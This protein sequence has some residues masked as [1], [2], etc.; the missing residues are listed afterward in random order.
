MY[1]IIHTIS[2]SRSL[3]WGK[4]SLSQSSQ[5]FKW[6]SGMLMLRLFSVHRIFKFPQNYSDFIVVVGMSEGFLQYFLH[7]H[8]QVFL[9]SCVSDRS[10]STFQPISQQSTANSYC[11]KILSL[12]FG[13][14]KKNAFLLLLLNFSF[15]QEL[16]PQ[17]VLVGSSVILPY[18][19]LQKT[20]SDLGSGVFLFFPQR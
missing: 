11:F 16:F 13:K 7:P 19:Q 5:K 9:C 12:C 2:S 6:V 15:R 1:G 10:L 14:R 20:S 8:L 17:V 4:E 18:P 3:V